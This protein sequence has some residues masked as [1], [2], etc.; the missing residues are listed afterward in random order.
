MKKST[1]VFIILDIL[2]AVCFFVTY[3]IK[4]FKNTIIA[5]AMSTK[6]HQWIAYTFYS[7]DSINKVLAAEAY[8]PFDEGTNLDDIVIDTTEK[9]SYDNEYE[10]QVLTRDEGND[11]YKL[12][13]IRE[14]VREAYLVV[15]YDP[16]KVKLMHAQVF[17]Q[18]GRGQES[19]LSMCQRYGAVAGINGGLFVDYGTGSD[20]PMGYVIKDGKIIWSDTNGPGELVAMTYDNKLLLKSMTGE[21]AINLGVRDAVQFGPFLMVNGKP[22]Q[23]ASEESVGGYSRAAR[24]VIAQRKDGIMFFLVTKGATHGTSAGWT[25]GELID[26][27]QRYGAYNAA[28]MDGGTSST[29]VLNNSV[30]NNPINIF[31]EPTNGG[32]G[33]YVVDGWGLIP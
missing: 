14:G 19:V 30:I 21:E 15:I 3:G 8:I 10:E 6:T 26:V 2:V 22:L 12:I 11:L 7:D 27:L 25:I 32:I 5:T 1:I 16:S 33:R 20:I 4:N 28:N 24:T 9:T 29:L 17:N 13:T 23:F 31:G 18:N